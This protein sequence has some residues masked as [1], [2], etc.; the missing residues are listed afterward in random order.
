[1]LNTQYEFWLDWLLTKSARDRL[2][3]YVRTDS[4]AAKIEEQYQAALKGKKI[5]ILVLDNK[6]HQLFLVEKKCKAV[7]RWEDEVN[8]LL[9]RQGKL[10]TEMKEM[11]SLKSKLLQEIRDN[12]EGAETDTKLQKKQDKNQRLVKEINEKTDNYENELDELPKK[13]EAANR[14]LMIETVNQFYKVLKKNEESIE[15]IV[16]WVQAIREQVKDNLVQKTTLEDYNAM[17][18]GYL[19]DALGGDVVD[20]FDLKYLKKKK[21][22]TIG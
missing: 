15:E 14:Q 7:R 16:Q 1:M 12:M 10:G 11:K 2:E 22:E 19:H 9:Q 8:Q 17:I 6:W 18:Y 20:V 5:P 13:L 3:K 21:E 4:M